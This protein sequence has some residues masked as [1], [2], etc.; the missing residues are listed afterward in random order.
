MEK[1][2][3][4]DAEPNWEVYTQENN[5]QSDDIIY[6]MKEY[7]WKSYIKWKISMPNTWRPNNSTERK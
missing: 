1:K 6:R 7:I 2:K 4:N 5:L 3:K